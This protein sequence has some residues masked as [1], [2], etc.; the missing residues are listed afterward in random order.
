MLFTDAGSGITKGKRL[1][2]EEKRMLKEKNRC[3]ENPTEKGPTP[4][5]SDFIAH[6]FERSAS[7]PSGKGPKK[8]GG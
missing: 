4:E 2:G 7:S 8:G 6:P 3:L 5:G 1:N